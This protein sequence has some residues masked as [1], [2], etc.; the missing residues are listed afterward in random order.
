MAIFVPR[1][2]LDVWP[3]LALN[4]KLLAYSRLVSDLRRCPASASCMV[5]SQGCT[6]RPRQ[7]ACTSV[8]CH[9]LRSLGFQPLS[10]ASN[11]RRHLTHKRDSRNV[12]RRLCKPKPL[13]SSKHHLLLWSSGREVASVGGK[14]C[15]PGW[16]SGC[17]SEMMEFG[18]PCVGGTEG[19]GSICSPLL[20][21]PQTVCC[22]PGLMLQCRCAGA[23][24]LLLPST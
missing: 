17:A 16:C 12:K 2:G 21:F 11:I 23:H 18:L 20:P 3:R 22:K 6:T 8:C 10:S 24:P 9:T 13:T 5:G 19:V 7:P 15:F 1:Q 14:G 4:L